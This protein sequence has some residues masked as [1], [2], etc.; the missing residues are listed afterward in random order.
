MAIGF[1]NHN[2]DVESAVRRASAKGILTF[3]A[4]SNQRNMDEIYCPANMNG[5]FFGIF[6][7]NTGNR[8]SRGLNPSMAVGSRRHCFAIF[9]EDLEW[10]PNEPLVRGTSYSTSM[11]AGLAALLLQFSRQRADDGVQRPRDLASLQ[12]MS[13]MRAVFARISK[14]DNSC[15]C[16]LPW[17]LLNQGCEP[18]SADTVEVARSRLDQRDWVRTTIEQCL[19]DRYHTN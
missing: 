7:T 15:D 8:E 6:A 10:N 5:C 16:I 17:K 9:G 18:K 2:E 4:A 14:R 1:K 13:G 12:E 19:V 3:L 11:A